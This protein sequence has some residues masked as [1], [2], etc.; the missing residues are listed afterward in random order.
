[1]RHID[2]IVLKVN[3]TYTI[4]VICISYHIST[5]IINTL[6]FLKVTY[7]FSIFV[8]S[9]VFNLKSLLDFPEGGRLGHGKLNVI[10][11]AP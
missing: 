5:H 10:L 9:S 6:A 1:M 11:G 8:R 7:K 4:D 3:Y 2:I